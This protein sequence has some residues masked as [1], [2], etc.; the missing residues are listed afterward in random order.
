MSWSQDLLSHLHT[1]LDKEVPHPL[2]KVA[3]KTCC[4]A[5]AA[6]ELLC[7]QVPRQKEVLGE[8]GM[9]TLLT[10]IRVL[11]SAPS[12]MYQQLLAS[13]VGCIR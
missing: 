4:S 3:L 13:C 12:L 10:Y 6:L 2:D 7:Q 5:F 9:Q 8:P 11:P 1:C